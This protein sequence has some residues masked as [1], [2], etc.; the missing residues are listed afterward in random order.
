M[1]HQESL[2]HR[3]ISYKMNSRNHVSQVS[4]ILSTL[5]WYSSFTSTIQNLRWT[6]LESTLK[7]M[8]VNVQN[9]SFEYN[10]T[11]GDLVK[12]GICQRCLRTVCFHNDHPRG[13]CFAPRWPKH[14]P[15]ESTCTCAMSSKTVPGNPIISGSND[16]TKGT[17]AGGECVAPLQDQIS[18]DSQ[19][20]T[21]EHP[22][23]TRNHQKS[24]FFKMNEDTYGDFLGYQE[25]LGMTF[26]TTRIH[27]TW[28]QQVT[29]VKNSKIL[30]K[31][32]RCLTSSARIQNLGWTHLES[33]LNIMRVNV[34]NSSFGY[35]LSFEIWISDG[36]SSV[37]WGPSDFWILCPGGECFAP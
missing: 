18:Q 14:K 34:E 33:T 23:S 29:F 20:L 8:M 35:N 3:E 26:D 25:S 37:A 31:L 27:K 36:F 21:W 1:R 11:T 17:R 16:H 30:T 32:W 22:K 6:Q 12:R 5:L 10:L 19:D 2:W 28:F 15:C 13:E 24:M 7:I 9:S 4:K